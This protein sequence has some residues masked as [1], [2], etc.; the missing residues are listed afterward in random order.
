MSLGLKRLKNKKRRKNIF[1]IYIEFCTPARSKI[2]LTF[3]EEAGYQLRFKG[4]IKKLFRFRKRRQR[5]TFEAYMN[6]Q[7]GYCIVK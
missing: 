7:I 5:M 2:C 1:Y 4:E 6:T 3:E